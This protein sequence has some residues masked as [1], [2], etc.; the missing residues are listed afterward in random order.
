MPITEYLEPYV[1]VDENLA[2]DAAGRL[3][4]QPWSVPELV[5]D[6]RAKSSGDGP[7]A[8]PWTVLPGRLMIEQQIHWHN[9]A[10]T[11]RPLLIRVTRGPRQW[12]TSQPN[13]I[14][15]RD[16]WTY[17]VDAEPS[18]PLTSSIFNGRT[19]SALDLGTNSVAEPLPGVQFMWTEV[20][21]VDEWLPYPIEPNQSF[22]LW[23]RCY[24]WTPPPWSDNAN[25]NSPTH[26]AF[27]NWARLQLIAFPDQ[28]SV[29]TG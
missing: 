12:W 23:Y 19:G 27:A 29:V 16:R 26:A 8:R 11:A 24:M 7:L 2:V 10:P 25:Q 18:P 14:Q 21:S 9:N 17:A 22:S 13:A 3:R 6:V 20:N 28:G 4:L 15:F 5:V 1:C